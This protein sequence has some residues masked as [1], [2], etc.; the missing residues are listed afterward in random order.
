MHDGNDNMVEKHMGWHNSTI[1][2]NDLERINMDF[3]DGIERCSRDQ[4]II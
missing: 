4:E 2:N 1:C 3:V